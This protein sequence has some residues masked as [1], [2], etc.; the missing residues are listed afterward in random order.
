MIVFGVIESIDGDVA[1]VKV[2]EHDNAVYECYML[3]PLA[4]RNKVD[5]PYS[6][7]DLVAVMLSDGRNLIIGEVYNDVDTRDT[8]AGDDTYVFK[9]KKIYAKAEDLFQFNNG[10]NGGMVIVQNLVNRLNNIEN[11]LSTHQH[12]YVSPGGTVT[13][14]TAG[15]QEI[16]PVTAVSDLENDKVKH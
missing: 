15:T 10:L 12:S 6:V 14:T 3:Q 13:T 1:K 5:L 9:S 7:D 11:K 2:A 4:G 16:S 8:N